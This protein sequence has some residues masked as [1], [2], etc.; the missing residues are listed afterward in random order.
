MPLNVSGMAIEWH[1]HRV[2]ARTQGPT[3]VVILFYIFLSGPNRS[4]AISL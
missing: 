2:L 1:G 3:A 4:S